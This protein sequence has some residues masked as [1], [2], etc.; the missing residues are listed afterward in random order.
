VG[1]V[2]YTTLFAPFFYPPFYPIWTEQT[3]WQKGGHILKR[4]F[5]ID[6]HHNIGNLHI[7]LFGEFNGMCAWQLIKIIKQQYRGSGRIFIST[8]AIERIVPNGV[9]LFKSYMTQMPK[10]CLYFKGEKGFKIGP[11][12]SRVLICR[13]AQI[14]IK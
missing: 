10:D 4:E 1:I 8:S 9:D 2:K 12:G 14:S 5:C 6:F 13:K 3:T 11:D 7:H